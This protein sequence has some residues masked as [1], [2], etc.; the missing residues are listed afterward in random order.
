MTFPI[1]VSA[2]EL[3]TF[4][5]GLHRSREA[6][7]TQMLN[8]RRQADSAR[9]TAR[10]ARSTVGHGADLPALDAEIRYADEYADRCQEALDALAAL[11]QLLWPHP[12]QV[13]AQ[14]LDG[15]AAPE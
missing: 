8:A 12:S 2:D 4:R 10:L 15:G 11:L 1:T 14:L 6:L 7:R 5:L 9:G 13:A 3:V